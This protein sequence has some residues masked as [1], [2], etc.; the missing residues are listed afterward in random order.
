MVHAFAM[1]SSHAGTKKDTAT[2]KAITTRLLP[3]HVDLAPSNQALPAYVTVNATPTAT[4]RVQRAGDA[5]SGFQ[6]CGADGIIGRHIGVIAQAGLTAPIGDKGVA[7]LTSMPS[8]NRY[9]M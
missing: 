6:G 8:A 1:H 3:Q 9:K 4:C 5:V 7:W 2:A